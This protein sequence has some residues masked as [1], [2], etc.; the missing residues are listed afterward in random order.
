MALTHATNT[1]N[2]AADAVVD[3][4]DLGSG[5]ATGILRIM[6]AADATLVDLPFSNPAFGAAA[7]GVA[8]A[9]AITTTAATG[10]GTAAKFAIR[11]RDGNVVVSGTV[12]A[13]GGGGDITLDSTSITSGQNVAMTSLTY[14][15]FSA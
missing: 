12:T 7:A 13:T 6:T 15:P 14:T 3:R 11:D 10:T 4:I 9:S 5:T 2:A 8:T 1:K